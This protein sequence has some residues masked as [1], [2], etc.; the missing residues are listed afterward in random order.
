[1]LST[2]ILRCL[3]KNVSLALET[4]QLQEDCGV[5][6]VKRR[7]RR[8]ATK[9]HPDKRGG[10]ET[11]FRNLQDQYHTLLTWLAGPAVDSPSPD[12]ITTL[13]TTV[14]QAIDDRDRVAFDKAFA[15]CMQPN[16]RFLGSTKLLYALVE[17]MPIRSSLSLEH[18]KSCLAAI[19]RWEEITT[20]ACA[21]DVF[22]AVL[23]PYAFMKR[24]NPLED[25]VM[26]T[27]CVTLLVE[28][29]QNRGFDVENE[30]W[31]KRLIDKALKNSG[32]FSTPAIIELDEPSSW[33][34]AR[35][36]M[37][38]GGGQPAP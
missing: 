23:Y 12:D 35:Q 32:K 4:F 14:R 7:Y 16:A 25:G 29:M 36:H 24:D 37:E 9:A 15:T 31:T 5:D 22:N 20:V 30:W 11:Q 10:C 1:M 6:A 28:E 34:Q 27:K 3:P 18:T 2:R 8:L 38:T 17:G 21:S 33:V 13:V 19:R 26:I